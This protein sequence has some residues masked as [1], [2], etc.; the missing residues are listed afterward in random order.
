[1]K[2][3]PVVEEVRA[4]REALF[5]RFDYDLDALCDELVRQSEPL[6]RGGRTVLLPPPRPEPIAA[7]A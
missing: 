5:A 4:N 2:N 3:D 1:M 6:N 7:A